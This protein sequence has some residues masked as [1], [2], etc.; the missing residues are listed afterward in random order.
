M[1]FIRELFKVIYIYI[2][3][4]YLNINI[5]KLDQRKKQLEIEF[6]MGRD[7]KPETIDQMID[8]LT[9]WFYF[10]LFLFNKIIFRSNQSDKLLESIQ[11]KINHANFEA[12]SDKQHKIEFEKNIE[13]SFI[14]FFIL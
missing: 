8:I 2:Y 4:K 5:G 11:E 3:L 6:T 14:I 9:K 1:L 12:E 10:F 7:L 13:K